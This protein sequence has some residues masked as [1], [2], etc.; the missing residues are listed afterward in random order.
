MFQTC[1]LAL[2]ELV[3]AAGHLRAALEVEQVQLLAEVVMRDDLVG[4]VPQ[5]VEP[6]AVALDVVCLVLAGRDRFV[7]D[8]RQFQQGLL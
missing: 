8:V 1:P 7:R 4:Q 6:L 2:D 3:A 5:V